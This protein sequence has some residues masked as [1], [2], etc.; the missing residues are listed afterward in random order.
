MLWP[1]ADSRAYPPGNDACVILDIRG[2]GVPA[3]LFL[4]DLSASPQRAIEASGLLDPPYDVVK[5][6][7]HGSADQEPRLYRLAAPS[8]ALITVGLGNDYGHP[9]QETLDVLEEIGAV[10]A[11]TDREGVARRV[12]DTG[13]RRG[14]ARTL[15]RGR[16]PWLGLSHGTD[17]AT[18][19][20][21][22][23]AHRHSP[24]L[25]ARS[26]AGA[27]RAHLGS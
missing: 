19:R 14:L 13:R 21:R 8:V 3:S 16:A 20:S 23:A 24:A 12:A 15:R 25:M 10:V 22:E 6:A 5:V 27:D 11:R 4:G 17:S 7:H 26:A 1:R 2:G 18:L 9:R